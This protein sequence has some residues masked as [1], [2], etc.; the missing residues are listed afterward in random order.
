[1]NALLRIFGVIFIFTVLTIGIFGLRDACSPRDILTEFHRAE[2]VERV[3]EAI[4]RHQDGQYQTVQEWMKQR[5]TWEEAMQRLQE[6]DQDMEEVWPGYTRR[7]RETTKQS[8]EER[9]YQLILHYVKT[10]LHERP[11]E[12]AVVLGRLEKDSRRLPPGS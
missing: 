10:V 9:H 6:L 1:M 11:E 7:M 4:V 3:H 12:L 8:D 5:C 2:E